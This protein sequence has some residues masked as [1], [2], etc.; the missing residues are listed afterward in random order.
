MRI[1]PRFSIQSLF[2]GGS[3]F[4]SVG[5]SISH[6]TLRN[7]GVHVGP[8]EAK[9]G[10]T[11]TFKNSVLGAAAVKNATLQM[12]VREVLTSGSISSVALYTKKYTGQ[13]FAKD[14]KRLYTVTYVVPATA[15]TG[16]YT[17]VIKA[18]SG[19]GKTTYFNIA[20]KVAP[21]VVSIIGASSAPSPTPTATPSPSPSPVVDSTYLRGINIMDLGMGGG[22]LPGKYNYNYTRPS[23][24][25]LKHLK[26]RGFQVVRFPFNWERIQPKLNGPLDQAY[27]GHL[28]GMVKD[29]DSA[30]LKAIID[31]HN[32]GR[33]HHVQSNGEKIATIIGDTL[34]PVG[35]TTTQYTDAWRKIAAAFR[36]DAKA[37]KAVYA[38]DLM[39]EPHDLADVHAPLA[40]KATIASFESSLEGFTK[41]TNIASQSRVTRNGQMS[42]KLSVPVVKSDKPVIYKA[43]LANVGSKIL[44]ANGNVIQVKG[45]VPKTNEGTAIVR[46]YLIS[47]KG[48]MT[49]TPSEVMRKDRSF[50]LN[51]FVP[52]AGFE[53]LSKLQMEI[54]VNKT[55]GKNSEQVFFIDEIAQGTAKETLRAKDVWV[56]FAQAAVDGIRADGDKKL[57]MVEGYQWASAAAWTKHHPTKFIKDSA[58]NLMYHAHLYLDYYTSGH[59]ELPF[60]QETALAKSAGHASVGAQGVAR[61]KVFGNWCAKEKVRCFI[62]EYGWPNSDKVGVSEARQW[63]EAGEMLLKYLDS[64][65]M[66]ATLWGTASWLSP[67]DNILNAYQLERG[68]RPFLPLS[69]SLIVEKHLGGK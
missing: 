13:N 58:N 38:Y 51:I 28:I 35:P 60:A 24:T 44:K 23:L 10:Q 7:A 46:F 57:I 26:S 47:T 19:D 11:I 18:L 39:N 55:E 64:V 34:A 65:K 45:F 59:Y 20:Q 4:L 14:E 43:T 17:Y 9:V 50:A 1:I 22:V 21:Y 16:K 31:F 41:S 37:Y 68:T 3:I 63:D 30:G 40:K 36:A 32:Y 42:M 48:V 53:N 56:K 49:L 33:Y 5:F 8:T 29:A 54:I 2:V 62:G 67:T 25:N 12:E 66:G 27:L 15:K 52:Q 6:A 69:Q 61:A